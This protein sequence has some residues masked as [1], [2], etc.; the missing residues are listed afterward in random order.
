MGPLR[1][2]M[3]LLFFWAAAV[4]V[5]VFVAM[6]VAITIEFFRMIFPVRVTTPRMR[7]RARR[8]LQLAMG[9]LQPNGKRR[10]RR[11]W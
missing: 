5:F 4:T 7:R 9:E 2:V 1:A 11:T 8:N 6:L 3:W 10:M